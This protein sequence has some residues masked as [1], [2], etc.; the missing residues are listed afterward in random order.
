[1]H[2]VSR[3]YQPGD[4]VQINRL[5][6][7]ITGR[8]RSAAEFAWEWLDTWAGQGSINLVFDLD[9]EEGDQLIA[10][11]S[12]IP[13][14]LS[15]WGRPMVAGKT[16]NCMS[17]PDY[18]GT[19]LYSEHERRC[20]AD[21]KKKYSFFFTT[22]GQVTGGA[23]GK[24]RTKLGY[25]PFDDWADY[26]LWL[27]TATL[28]DDIRGFLAAKGGAWETAA[29]VVS[30]VVAAA[31]QAYSHLRRRHSCRYRVAVHGTGDAPL[32]EIA[33]LWERNRLRYGISVDRSV[34]Y[35]QWRVNDDPHVEHEYLTISGPGGL[36]GYAI[37]FVQ[38][39]TLHIV[40]LL[41]DDARP[42][43]FRDLLAAVARRGRELG[44]V[45]VRCRVLRRSSLLPR[46]L[47]S[48][49]FIDAGIRSPLSIVR[50]SRPRQ[51]FIYV[52]E[53]LRDDPRILDH[54][55]WYV[56]GLVLEGLQRTGSRV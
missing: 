45:R 21:E 55:N 27:R 53:E 29:P 37:S 36:L 13:T 14:P 40:D 32:E 19:G 24:I 47:R 50:G 7:L 34:R 11:Y 42:D 52:P 6:R 1:L 44:V 25:V 43:L 28:R 5:Y 30:G 17:H 2:T 49:G 22:A 51:F 35:L 56:T 12:L 16:E 10:Q 54:A 41:V 46:R 38:G 3:A 4:E 15:L 18:R 23:V 33:A 9:R 39:D 8:D 20:F 26:T 31:L 48:G